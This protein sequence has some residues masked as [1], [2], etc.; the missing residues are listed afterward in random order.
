MNHISAGVVLLML[1]IGCG[2]AG[3]IQWRRGSATPGRLI[4]LIGIAAFCVGLSIWAFLDT[5]PRA[6]TRDTDPGVVWSDGSGWGTGSP[7]S[8]DTSGLQ[9]TN[10]VTSDS[11]SWWS[12]NSDSGSWEAAGTDSGSWYTGSWDSG[13]WDSGGFDGGGDGGDGG[14]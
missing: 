12:G 7:Q 14:D 10:S 8:T 9:S 2:V 4:E 6:V 3:L 11:G 5:R 13:S 1:A